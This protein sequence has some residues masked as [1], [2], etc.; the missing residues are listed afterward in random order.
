[1]ASLRHF[2]ALAKNSL[3]SNSFASTEKCS[4][5]LVYDRFCLKNENYILII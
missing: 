5:G 4:D 1:M 2:S 3:C